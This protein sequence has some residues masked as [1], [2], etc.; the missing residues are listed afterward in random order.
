MSSRYAKVK[1]EEADSGAY[2]C[3][4]YNFAC[5]GETLPSPYPEY[6]ITLDMTYGLIDFNHF[7][8]S[9]LF[10]VSDSETGEVERIIKVYPGHPVVWESEY[11]P[12]MFD[13][14]ENN[15]GFELV[16]KW[17]Y[18]S[19]DTGTD[20]ESYCADYELILAGDTVQIHDDMQTFENVYSYGTRPECYSKNA[21]FEPSSGGFTGL[22]VP[23]SRFNICDGG[24]SY[25][26]LTDYIYFSEK[27]T[28]PIEDKNATM[29][30]SGVNTIR[31]LTRVGNEIDLGHGYSLRLI[32]IGPGEGYPGRHAAF[33]EVID[34]TTGEIIDA[35]EIEKIFPLESGEW[36]YLATSESVTV[37]VH[38]TI[39][40]FPVY[41]QWAEV[42]IIYPELSEIE[43]TFGNSF[44]PSEIL[45]ND[46]LHFDIEDIVI[47]LSDPEYSGCEGECIVL[48]EM[49]TINASSEDG[50]S[51]TWTGREGESTVV[52]GVT[53]EIVS[54]DETV[55]F[56]NRCCDKCGD[57]F[58][59]Y[60]FT[61][62]IELGDGFTLEVLSFDYGSPYVTFV[63][64]DSEGESTGSGTPLE[65]MEGVYSATLA[66]D[67]PIGEEFYFLNA[68]FCDQNESDDGYC[69]RL[70][71]FEHIGEC[72]GFN[73]TLIP[74]SRVVELGGHT[75][76]D[77]LCHRTVAGELDYFDCPEM[78]WLP[79]LETPGADPY[80][81]PA[82]DSESSEFYTTG[83]TRIGHH[84]IIARQGSN[85]CYTTVQV[86]EEERICS[87]ITLKIYSG[88]NFISLPIEPTVSDPALLFPDVEAV[89]Y[90]DYETNSF[91]PAESI[92][93]GKGYVIFSVESQFY[94]IHG[95]SVDT[96][97]IPLGF[98]ELSVSG[99]HLIG[100]GCS[101]RLAIRDILD[102]DVDGQFLCYNYYSDS[103]YSSSIIRTG[104]ACFVEI[105]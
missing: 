15:Y 73:C 85:I 62:E 56:A 87:P 14:C 49:I 28:C 105:R 5:I 88:Y 18:Y 102:D 21:M 13:V 79:N 66:F 43:V 86:V 70:N 29:R 65:L 60:D 41:T 20:G 7:S 25:Y 38:E 19:I 22:P 32:F 53:V 23:S 77:V 63:V 104:D 83:S 44:L 4:I 42:E 84:N 35:D 91:Q 78:Q 92:E 74:E 90:W 100:P 101:N 82:Y 89:W 1:V 50:S 45:I 51:T 68:S 30:F 52:G 17:S 58:M 12:L 76:V 34:T 8:H 11:G 10:I 37:T 97:E 75:T 16:G 99:N 2:Y 6:T 40:G 46:E 31:M 93:A 3:G 39:P 80:M 72:G 47:T 36:T 103:Y 95:E 71:D 55:G 48:D 9:T 57:D 27:D 24:L 98:P 81:L 94:V 69:F 67:I 33:F 64:S 59:H 96:L 54:I 26:S 61:D